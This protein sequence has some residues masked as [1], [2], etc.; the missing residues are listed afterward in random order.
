MSGH[1][2]N[3]QVPMPLLRALPSASSPARAISAT[4]VS[5]AAIILCGAV[6]GVIA[7][8][9]LGPE[10]RG[11]LAVLMFWPQ[12]LA[13]IGM[14]SIPDAVVQQTAAREPDERIGRSTSFVL[15]MGI[16]VV[17]AL[18]AVVAMPSLI[19]KERHTWALMSQLYVA[20]YIPFYGVGLVLLGADQGRL[21]FVRYN[22][23]RSIP[24][25]LYLVA[26][27]ALYTTGTLTVS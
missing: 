24:P 13:T 23:L 12:L 5:N 3:R 26:C 18:A 6:T 2:A 15:G 8:R 25:I 19:G 1:H 14:L 20:I 9:V 21:N 4:F 10:A 16:A 17:A 11:T 27:V 7:A 22:S